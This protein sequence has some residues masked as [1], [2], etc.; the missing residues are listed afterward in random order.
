[1][2]STTPFFRTTLFRTWLQDGSGVKKLKAVLGFV[3]NARVPHERV[4]KEKLGNWNVHSTLP[5]RVAN[6]P[7]TYRRHESRCSILRSCLSTRRRSRSFIPLRRGCI[8]AAYALW[9]PPL[10]TSMRSM[11]ALSR[12]VC[13]SV[14]AS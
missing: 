10:L 12:V 14:Q 7:S 1:M 5:K 11:G 8:Y 6:I 9:T 3:R 4:W 13:W 2:T